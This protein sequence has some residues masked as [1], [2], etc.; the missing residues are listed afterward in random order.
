MIRQWLRRATALAVALLV[1]YGALLAWV[2]FVS[3]ED[4]QRPAKPLCARVAGFS[5]HAAQ[6]VAAEDRK[7]LERLCRYGLRPAFAQD[8]LSVREDGRVLYQLR[9]PW[10]HPEGSTCLV[11][12]PLDF[13]RRLAALIPAPYAHMVRYHDGHE[14]AGL[15][16]LAGVDRFHGHRWFGANAHGRAEGDQPCSRLGSMFTKS[17]PKLAS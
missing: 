17:I 5:L 7:A 15:H 1:V 4:Q 10:P 11:L 6:S 9:R 12:E 8:R 13:L 16:R 2:V 3:R 14:A